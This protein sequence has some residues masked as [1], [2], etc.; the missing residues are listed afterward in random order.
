MASKPDLK[1]IVGFYLKHLTA[2]LSFTIGLAANSPKLAQA[3]SLPT[4]WD[5]SIKLDIKSCPVEPKR[6]C[7]N[8]SLVP[9]T[10][11]YCSVSMIELQVLDNPLGQPLKL[12]IRVEDGLV[13]SFRTLKR[14]LGPRVSFRNGKMALY[15]HYANRPSDWEQRSNYDTCPLDVVGVSC[16]KILTSTQTSGR[17][18]EITTFVETSYYPRDLTDYPEMSC[19]NEQ[20]VFHVESHQSGVM[21][22]LSIYC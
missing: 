17:N 12:L 2:G 21:P 6:L 5:G 15:R 1:K 10:Q 20:I 18:P 14:D 9:I 16:K 19:I 13:K 8:G 22:P 4:C 3:D 11:R 7:E